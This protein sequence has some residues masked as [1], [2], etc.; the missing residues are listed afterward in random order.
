MRFQ[1]KILFTAEYLG[2]VNGIKN[3]MPLNSARSLFDHRGSDEGE[4]NLRDGPR[5]TANSDEVA[6]HVIT[7]TPC[8]SILDTSNRGE[9]LEQTQIPLEGIYILSGP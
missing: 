7:I 5:T 1:Q 9:T 3:W 6:Q 4:I 8:G 2:K